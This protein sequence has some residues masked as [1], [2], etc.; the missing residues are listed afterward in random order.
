MNYKY[1]KRTTLW[2]VILLLVPIT[3]SIGVTQTLEN[4]SI[5]TQLKDELAGRRAYLLGPGDVLHLN[6]WKDEALSRQVIVLPDGTVSLPLVGK[7][8]AAGKAVTDLED[9]I[10]IKIKKYL[11]N[12]VLDISVTQVNSMLIYVIGKVNRPG[13]FPITAE[14]NVLQALAMAGGLD[15]HADEG[16]IKIYREQNSKTIFFNFDYDEVVDGEKLKQ[17]IKLMKGDVV[18][19]P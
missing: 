3:D 1:L 15:K 10:K 18:V 19:V 5:K 6:V 14:V 16:G 17:N 13:H 11:P 4:H 7:L 12:P 9:E 2:V 8:M